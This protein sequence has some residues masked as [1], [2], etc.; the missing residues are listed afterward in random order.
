MPYTYTVWNIFD[1]NLYSLVYSL[2]MKTYYTYWKFLNLFLDFSLAFQFTPLEIDNHPCTPEN[3]KVSN[4]YRI[5]TFIKI[6]NAW[7]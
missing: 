2:M 3:L 7:L 4:N 6:S 5:A 1:Q